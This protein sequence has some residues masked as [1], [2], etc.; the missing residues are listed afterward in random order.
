MTAPTTPEERIDNAGGMAPI[1]D[2][3]ASRS[4][5]AHRPPD[6]AAQGFAEMLAEPL[7]QAIVNALVEA[8]TDE[9]VLMRFLEAQTLEV[10]LTDNNTTGGPLDQAL[11][12]FIDEAEKWSERYTPISG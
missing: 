11:V 2:T 5:H 12:T 10:G 8:C 6:R 1:P 3:E 7:T 9:S 4:R